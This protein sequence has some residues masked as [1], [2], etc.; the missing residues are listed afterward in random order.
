MFLIIIIYHHFHRY[1]FMKATAVVYES[2]SCCY[3]RQ[4][5]RTFAEG[6]V[7]GLLAL[8]PSPCRCGSL[9]V[10]GGRGLQSLELGFG[11]RV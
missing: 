8:G 4:S 3:R 10:R 11:F 5:S 2:N 7:R 9:V 6:T 1:Q